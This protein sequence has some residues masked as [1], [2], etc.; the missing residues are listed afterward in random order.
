MKWIS[1]RP[2]LSAIAMA[3]RDE[4]GVEARPSRAEL[5]IEVGQ[6]AGLTGTGVDERRGSVV[7]GEEVRV[8][9]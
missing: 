7:A 6:M 4:H 8:V 3:M 1:P 5:D 2:P 9:A